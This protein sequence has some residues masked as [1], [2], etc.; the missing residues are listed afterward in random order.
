[1]IL[2]M[3]ATSTKVKKLSMHVATLRIV[4]GIMWAIDAVFKFQPSFRNGFINQIKT[5]TLGQPSWLKPWFH[6]WVHF[7]GY[8][9][10]LFALLTA[11]IESFIACSLLLGLARRVTYLSAAFFSLL[12]W[13]IAEGFGGPYTS[14]S[15]DIGAAI[16]YAVVFFALYGLERLT[17]TPKWSLDNYIIQ[18]LQWWAVIANP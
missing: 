4:F 12:V 2:K 9:P 17:V 15:T 3:Y 7:L 5:A 13:A 10:H 14:S 1:M 11:I 8:N 6:F 16:I 18:H